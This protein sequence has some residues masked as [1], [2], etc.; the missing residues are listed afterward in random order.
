[1]AKYT[2]MQVIEAMRKS[3]I[4]PVFYHGDIEVCTKIIQASYDGGA[5]VFEFTSRGDSAHEVFGELNKY[6]NQHLEGMILGVGSIIDS[7][8]AAIYLQLGAN[9]VV[10]PIV[11][12]DMAEICNRR[13]VAWIP[14]CGTVT[15]I[16]YADELGA[17]LVKIFP[18]AQ[19]GGAD[20]VAAVKAPFPWVK[21]MPTGGVCT[22]KESLKKWFDA[23][24]HCVGIGSKL[25]K[26][27]EHG[28]Y[29]FHAISKE[30]RTIL[31]IVASFK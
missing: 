15:E 27:Q 17:E 10:S 5:R 29:E 18:A 20:F 8:G 6:V 30:I 4:I 12:K 19:I 23:G 3:G 22:K 24:A 31:G 9:F 11:R 1:M 13:K 7:E 25:F 16:S 14:G 21:I 28:E 2:R 26:K